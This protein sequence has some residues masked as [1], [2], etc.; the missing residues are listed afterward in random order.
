VIST[1]IRCIVARS[2]FDLTKSVLG[3][4]PERMIESTAVALER[5]EAVLETL[6]Q[7]RQSA[8]RR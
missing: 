1:G 6:C 7:I 3:I 4:L 8:P 2:S 5:A